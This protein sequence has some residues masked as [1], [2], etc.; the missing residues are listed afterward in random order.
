MLSNIFFDEFTVFSNH[1]LSNSLTSQL[2]IEGSPFLRRLIV[3]IHGTQVQMDS[4]ARVRGISTGS[5]GC[6]GFWFLLERNCCLI[7]QSSL[8]SIFLLVLNFFQK[9]ASFRFVF[10]QKSA[11]AIFQFKGVKER[12]VLVILKIDI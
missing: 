2:G 1:L 3:I 6:G 11:V 9:A 4:A 5:G 12:S 10:K 8:G 7:A